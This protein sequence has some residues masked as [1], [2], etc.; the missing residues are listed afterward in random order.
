MS[1]CRQFVDDTL[2]RVSA[3]KPQLVV[4]ANRSDK[5]VNLR[6]YY[7]GAEN[8]GASRDALAVTPP[9][10]AA[11]YEAGLASALRRLGAGGVPTVVIHPVPHLI[12]DPSKCAA[13]LVLEDECAANEPLAAVRRELALA[14]AAEDRAAKTETLA[15]TVDLEPTL[16]PARVCRTV[17]DG[18]QM[19][20]DDYH[21]SIEGALTLTPTF[22]RLIRGHAA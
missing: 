9:A 15:S 4:I 1:R 13:T 19:Y 14:T 12:Y 16:C 22:T 18:I 10:K 5:Y 11:V 21:L 6:T 8:T 3:T 17:H 20:R 7:L 2:D